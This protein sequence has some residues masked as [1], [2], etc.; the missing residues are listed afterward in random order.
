MRRPS[1][2]ATALAALALAAPAAAAPPRAGV[3]DPG[4]SLGGLR[5]GMTQPQVRAAWGGVFGDCRGCSLPTWYFTYTAFKPQGA[6]VEFRLG[7]ADAIFTLWQPTGW[8]TR[9]GLQL[10]A[11]EEQVTSRYQ[12]FSRV[13][14]GKYSAL[15]LSTRNSF[16]VFYLVDGRLWG[17]G[18]IRRLVP[19]CR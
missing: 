19:P 2:T 13:E 7:R 8:R 6:G 12:A 9:G 10:G 18:L 1:A 4:R 3:F 16:S 11:R 15:L 14:C 17:F 5:L